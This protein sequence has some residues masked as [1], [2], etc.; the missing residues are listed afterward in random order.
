LKFCIFGLQRSGTTFLEFLLVNNFDCEIANNENWKHSLTKI[1]SNHIVFNIYKNPYTWI[2][3]I[4]FRDPADILVTSDSLLTPGYNIGHD[5]VNLANLAKLYNDY[6][7][8]WFDKDTFV[9]YESLIDDSRLDEFIQTLPFN[10]RN[11]ELEI[12][13][14]GSLFMSE[15]FSNDS[16]RYYL[17]G[18]PTLLTCSDISIINQ[19]ISNEVFDMLGYKKVD[20]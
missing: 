15:G 12:P 13:K 4:V 19:N 20:T 16:I 6:A 7:L 5:K 17:N 3:S 2:E 18:N 9:S 8:E 14:P 10:R 1:E 11:L